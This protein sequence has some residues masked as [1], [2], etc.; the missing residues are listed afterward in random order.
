MEWRGEY[1]IRVSR[2]GA[3]DGDGGRDGT[4][5][6]PLLVERWTPP[7]GRFGIYDHFLAEAGEAPPSVRVVPRFLFGLPPHAIAE[8]YGDDPAD[9]PIVGVFSESP[10]LVSVCVRTN[11]QT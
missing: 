4:S 7:S 1:E 6:S 9:L 2:D 8:M 10:R 11:T 5:P 3:G